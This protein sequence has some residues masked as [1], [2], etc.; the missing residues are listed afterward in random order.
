MHA[1]GGQKT[2]LQELVSFLPP[3]RVE[4]LDSGCEPGSQFFV[5]LVLRGFCSFK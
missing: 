3:G 2:T 1:C 4:G 5:C